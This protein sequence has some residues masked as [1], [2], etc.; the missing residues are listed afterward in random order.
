[1]RSVRQFGSESGLRCQCPFRIIRDGVVPAASL[2]MSA[3]HQKRL[4][5]CAATKRC[6]WSLV[7]ASGRPRLHKHADQK[8]LICDGPPPANKTGR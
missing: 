6:E 8:V 3:V 4:N 7:F 5:C 2:A 1:M